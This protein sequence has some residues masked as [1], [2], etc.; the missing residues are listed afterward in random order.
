MILSGS[1]FTTTSSLL[2][3]LLYSVVTHPGAQDRLL[4]ELI[5]FDISNKTQWTPKLA[6]SLPFL[7][8]FIMET[9]R[10]H[11]QPGWTMKTE[12]IVPSGY[13]LPADAV[14][15]HAIHKNSKISKDP[16]TFDPDRCDTPEVKNRCRAAYVPFTMGARGC[17][18]FNFAL[19]ENVACYKTFLR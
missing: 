5:D 6:N 9:Q 19:Q 1:G 15:F 7:D 17:V 18:S 8:K 13:C 11:N 4:Q 3:W 16:M 2:S 14:A 10:L 12:A